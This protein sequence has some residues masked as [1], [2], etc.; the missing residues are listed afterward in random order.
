MPELTPRIAVT[1]VGAVSALG[2]GARVTFERLCAGESGIRALTLFDP[3]GLPTRVAAEV[4]ELFVDG[5]ERADALAALAAR[6]ALLEAKWQ[7]ASSRLGLA[8]GTTAA[9]MP[10]TE[11]ELAAALAAGETAVWPRARRLLTHPLSTTEAALESEFGPFVQSSSVCS[12]CSSGGLALV[13]AAQWLLSGR[14]DAVLAGGVDP[15]CRMTYAGFGVLGVLDPEPCRPFDVS[16]R[17]LTLGEGAG[18]LLLELEANAQRRG[19]GVLAWLSGWAVGAEAHHVTQPDDSG[20]RAAQLIDSALKTAGRAAHEV[21]YVNAHGT[22]TP[23]NDAME[24]RAIESVFGEAVAQVAVSSNKGQL[25]HTLGAAGAIEAAICVLALEQQRVPPTRGLAQPEAP[26]LS[27]V[28][29]RGHALELEA[30]ISNSFG[31]G[32][33]DSVLL[34]E[35]ANAAAR[36]RSR[37]V[38]QLVITGVTALGGDLSGIGVLDVAADPRDALDAER[39]RRFDRATACAARLSELTLRASELPS[40][41]VGLVLGGAYGPVER[42]LKFLDRILS[43][44][45]RSGPPAE[46]PHL[47]KSAIAGNVSIYL[48]S[49]GPAFSVSALGVSGESTFVLAC[50][51]IALGLCDAALAVA[52]EVDDPVV[53]ELWAHERSHAPPRSE[54]GACLLV[55]SAEAAQ[56]RGRTP[57]ARVAS[58][59]RCSLASAPQNLP[60]PRERA[61]VVCAEREPELERALLNSAWANVERSFANDPGYH[62]ALGATAL[63]RAVFALGKGAEQALVLGRDAGA[64]FVIE[65]LAAEVQ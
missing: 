17:G 65:L 39:S 7:S 36:P 1:G 52:L 33:M 19:A 29:E 12:A 37:G 24:A 9:G 10:E 14:C 38:R 20:A 54:G 31:F 28:T 25:G 18:F 47:V 22:G 62:E 15:L 26:K 13:I 60:T 11:A 48:G 63:A 57:L 58:F 8:L 16:R 27:H 53:N 61:I 56:R 50:D 51:L 4:P 34:F 23:A 46:F 35:A 3:G 41:D 32:G 21:Q 40:H 43:R 42:S 2:Q 6:E 55:E 59:A 44:G 64:A 49:R 45:L 5:R 30:V